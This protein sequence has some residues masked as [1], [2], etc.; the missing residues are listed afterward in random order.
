[1]GYGVAALLL[2]GIRLQAGRPLTTDDADPTDQGIFE[3]E[4]GAAY[5]KDAEVR[6]WELPV[7]LA[8]G[9][10]PGFEVGLGWG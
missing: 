3:F 9:L 5:T 4:A 7:G 10:L 6:L 2:A 1:M 8:Y